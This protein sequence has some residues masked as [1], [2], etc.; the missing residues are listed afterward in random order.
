[1]AE[2]LSEVEGEVE[3]EGRRGHDWKKCFA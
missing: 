1:M 3:D 2:Q